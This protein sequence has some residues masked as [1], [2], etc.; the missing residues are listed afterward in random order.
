M[1]YILRNHVVRCAFLSVVASFQLNPLCRPP[2]AAQNTLSLIRIPDY[3]KAT[4]EE[5]AAPC[6]L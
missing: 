5:L 1:P 4:E 3:M 2:F 6:G